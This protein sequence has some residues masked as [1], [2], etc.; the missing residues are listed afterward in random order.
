MP[1]PKQALRAVDEPEEGLFLIRLVKGGPF[2]AARIWRDAGIW[3]AEIDGQ[4]KEP[5]AADPIQAAG[6]LKVWHYGQHT[7]EAEYLYRK[8]LGEW[9][10]AH[11]PDSPAAN[12]ERPIRLT[13]QKPI[14]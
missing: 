6:V 13:A 8:Q 3:R 9:A 1:H 10:R 2:V 14:F 7:T 12:P 5:G 4:V 11:D